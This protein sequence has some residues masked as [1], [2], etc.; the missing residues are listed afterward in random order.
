MLYSLG[1]ACC[2][3]HRAFSATIVHSVLLCACALYGIH[4]CCPHDCEVSCS[5]EQCHY[6]LQTML[7]DSEMISVSK[8]QELREHVAPPASQEPAKAAATG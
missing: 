2:C 8:L 7:G 6:L 5:V 3:A 4:T 1:R